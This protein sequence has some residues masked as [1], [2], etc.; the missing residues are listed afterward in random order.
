MDFWQA[1]KVFLIT[2]AGAIY[3]EGPYAPF[4]FQTS[5]LAWSTS[6]TFGSKAPLLVQKQSLQPK[7]LWKAY[8]QKRLGYDHSEKNYRPVW[9][10]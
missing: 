10:W 1:K 9:C 3:S 6:S 4:D 5:Y 2:A 7:R 8:S